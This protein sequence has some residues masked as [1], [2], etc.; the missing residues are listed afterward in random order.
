[1]VEGYRFALTC[2]APVSCFVYKIEKWYLAPHLLA[3]DI[4]GILGKNLRGAE[5]R[6]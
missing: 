4:R 6:G 1:M 3:F 2:L 5:R